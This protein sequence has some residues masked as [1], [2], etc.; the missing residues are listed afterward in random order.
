MRNSNFICPRCGQVDVT[1]SVIIMQGN[2][3]SVHDTERVTVKVCGECFDKVFESVQRQI[4]ACV[5]ET[6]FTL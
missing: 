3:G 4:P 1:P 2:Y 6:E 5:M